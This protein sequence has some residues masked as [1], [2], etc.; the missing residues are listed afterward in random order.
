[1]GFMGPM[2]SVGSMGSVGLST[3]VALS[4]L[5]PFDPYNPSDLF[6]PF[7]LFDPINP[8]GTPAVRPTRKKLGS[9]ERYST[10]RRAPPPLLVTILATN[11]S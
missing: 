3:T 11:L 6:N 4:P 10:E 5:N 8:Q 7:D 2:G 9:T 1:M